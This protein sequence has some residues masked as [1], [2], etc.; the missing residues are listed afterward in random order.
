MAFSDLFFLDFFAFLLLASS[1]LYCQA[2]CSRWLL[3]CSLQRNRIEEKK[4]QKYLFIQFWYLRTNHQTECVQF[5]FGHVFVHL[6]QLRG[7]NGTVDTSEINLIVVIVDSNLAHNALSVYIYS[8]LNIRCVV[9]FPRN[10]YFPEN[11]PFFVLSSHTHIHKLFM[12]ENNFK[13]KCD[14]HSAVA[15]LFLFYEHS[16]VLSHGGIGYLYAKL[17]ILVDFMTFHL[18]V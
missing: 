7:W 17:A 11:F 3:T 16:F 2:E 4:R 18:F 14:E 15:F 1:S 10:F 6:C 13:R 5:S 8:S 12:C 9:A